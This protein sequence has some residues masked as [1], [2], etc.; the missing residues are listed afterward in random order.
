M[1]AER[2]YLNHQIIE[3]NYPNP[4]RIYGVYHGRRSSRLCYG[5]TKTVSISEYEHGNLQ[6]AYNKIYENNVVMAT[7]LLMNKY[8]NDEVSKE[9]YN[10]VSKYKHY[11]FDDMTITDK[12]HF[13]RRVYVD[14]LVTIFNGTEMRIFR[15]Y[16]EMN[17]NDIYV[18]SSKYL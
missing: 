8:S 14:G 7:S 12:P 1:G 10:T 5:S 13:K 3:F 4:G 15:I 11:V 16:G 2:S 9:E 17:I 6:Y 18:Y